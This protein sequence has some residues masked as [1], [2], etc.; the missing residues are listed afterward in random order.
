MDAQSQQRIQ[1]AASKV[2][3]TGGHAPQQ[4]QPSEPRSASLSLNSRAHQ[5]VA[6]Q[7]L[8]QQEYQAKEAYQKK[9]N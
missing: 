2:S 5:V 3:G 4:Y 7:R 8:Q 1:R 9:Y 6:K